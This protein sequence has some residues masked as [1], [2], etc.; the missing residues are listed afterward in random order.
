MISDKHGSPS[1]KADH[2]TPFGTTSDAGLQ[3]YPTD[4]F[5]YYCL[6]KLFEALT[7]AAFYGKNWEYALDNTPQQR[8]MGK[9]SNGVPVKELIVTDLP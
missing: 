5:D 3:N 4:T 1:L 6:W 2:F 9:W 8:Y 7:D